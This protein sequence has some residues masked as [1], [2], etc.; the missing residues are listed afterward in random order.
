M[1]PYIDGSHWQLMIIIPKEY[2]V[3]W[4]CSLHRKPS[5]E[6]KFQLQGIVSEANIL[7]GRARSKILQFIYLKCNKQQDSFECDY[8]I[9]YWISAI[10]SA[11][12]TNSWGQVRVRLE[13]VVVTDA[14]DVEFYSSVKVTILGNCLIVL[15]RH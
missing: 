14:R 10:V 15:D 12:I 6:I 1:A 13:L 4:F 7:S 3:V 2:T 9:M 5:H 11:G 8:Y